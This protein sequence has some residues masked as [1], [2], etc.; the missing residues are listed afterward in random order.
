M[1]QKIDTKAGH[2]KQRIDILETI[3][4]NGSHDTTLFETSPLSRKQSM[5]N[6]VK[7]D[8]LTSESEEDLEVLDDD[9]ANIYARSI[10]KMRLAL[11]DTLAYS[12][13]QQ[14]SR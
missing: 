2:Q 10:M 7:A 13:N 11:E 3:S 8:I 9:T 4:P 1:L 6:K 12:D 5:R 14:D